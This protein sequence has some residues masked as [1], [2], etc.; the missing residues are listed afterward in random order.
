MNPTASTRVDVSIH[1]ASDRRPVAAL[2]RARVH[3]RAHVVVPQAR[4]LNAPRERRLRVAGEALPRGRLA[5]PSSG[6]IELFLR[7]G[8]SFHGLSSPALFGAAELRRALEAAGRLV[9]EV[10]REQSGVR[11]PRD[12]VVAGLVHITKRLERAL[13]QV[14]EHLRTPSARAEPRGASRQCRKCRRA[15]TRVEA[16]PQVPRGARRLRAT[17]AAGLAAR[18]TRGQP[19]CGSRSSAGCTASGP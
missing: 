8:V 18:S 2:R 6:L 12:Q 10:L 17:A 3:L 16:V 15:S 13:G 9:H 4:R 19:S 7:C 5:P 14:L 11:V 1:T